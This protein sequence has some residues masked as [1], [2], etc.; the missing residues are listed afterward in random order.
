MM[1]E[2][3]CLGGGVSEQ[4]NLD[5]TK[6]I[7]GLLMTTTREMVSAICSYWQSQ[8]LSVGI[9]VLE[10]LEALH[11]SK[12]NGY[13]F[14][15]ITSLLH[16][17]EVSKFLLDFQCH[18]LTNPYKKR[19]QYFLGISLSYLDIVFPLEWKKSVDEDLVSIRETDLSMNLLEEIILQTVEIKALERV[20]IICL[21]SRVSVAVYKN[22]INKLKL[23][24]QWKSFVE[25]I[26][27]RGLKDVSSAL[28]LSVGQSSLT[29]SLMIERIE[30]ILS[31]SE[32]GIRMIQRSKID[33]SYYPLLVLKMVMI[34]SLICLKLPK[35]SLRLLQ[36]LSGYGNYAYFLPKKF[37]SCLLRKSKNQELNLNL[38]VVAEAFSSV[39]DPLLIISSEDGSPKINA[40]CAIFV[41]LR[42]SKE[43]IISVLFP[44]KSTHNV[45]TSSNTVNGGAIPE[46]SSLE[47]LPDMNM[48]CVVMNW[49]VIEE[50]SEAINEKKGMALNKLPAATRIMNEVDI[51]RATFLLAVVARSSCSAME[52]QKFERFVFL[53]NEG[54]KLL[55]FAFDTS[56][57][58]DYYSRLLNSST[59]VRHAIDKYYNYLND[60]VL[61][62]V[63]KVEETCDEASAVPTL[64]AFVLKLG[65]GGHAEKMQKEKEQKD[66]LNAVKARLIYGEESGIKIRSREESHYSESKTPTARTELKRRHG[67]RYSRSPSPHASV[68]KR[69]KK[70]RSPSPR[71]RPRKEGGMFNRL[72]GKEP[73][74]SA[75]PDS[76]QRSPQAKRAEV[77]ARRRQQKGIQLITTSQYTKVQKVRGVTGNL[78]Q[79]GKGQ[80]PMKMIFPALDITDECMQLRKQIDEMIKVGKLSQF[81]KELKQNDKPKAPKKGEVS[82]K[83]KPLTILMI[84]PWERVAKP[85]ITQSFSPETAMSFPPLGE[86]DGTEGP[87]IIE[88]EMG[89]HFVQYVDGGASSEVLYEHC[90]I[91]LRKEIRDQMVPATTHLIGFSGETIWPLG[92]IALLVKIGDEVHSTS[93][94]MN[95][96][97]IRSPS[98]HNAIIGRPGI[99]KIRAVPSTA[100]GMLKFPVEGGTVTLQ[101]SRVIPMECAM[102]SGPST[103]T[104]A[105]NQVLEEKINIAIHPEYPEQT[106]AIGSTLT[107]KGRKELCSLLKQNLDIFAWKPAD[108]TGV[109]RNIAEHRLNI[110]EG[111][112]PVRQKKRGQAP[113][114]NKAIQE[115]V[116]KIKWSWNK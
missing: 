43:K 54:L 35:Y 78:S 109:P 33:D 59:G 18:N 91:K 13:A 7:F 46:G 114:R 65:G 36:H 98:Q 17:F 105:S 6:L 14:H 15:Q 101:S 55:S 85:R 87:M 25:E 2:G 16:I 64:A 68:F 40:A 49:K 32:F 47:T 39:D 21:Y 82:G 94:W 38:E 52:F 62:Q 66:K 81:I 42:K 88:A 77:E 56:V 108:M 115:E 80:T 27:D 99:R 92:Q 11:K 4:Q 67:G 19:L 103:Q 100:H 22:L 9:K 84:Q 83:D 61:N 70:Y 104:P 75:R 110:R 93:S 74:T 41:D 31:C 102:I 29:L 50:I 26:R 96:M 51:S 116:E 71:L 79:E 113:E 48:N 112:S 30:D 111:Y 95:F 60:Y 12:S 5:F 53:V 37:I 1:E 76:R 63:I 57:P 69:L 10:T 89:G 107:E 97:V 24:S 90:F 73:A 3:G 72:G 28:T 20:I 45:P 44:R 34:L 8:L 23:K 58:E 86:E 106:V